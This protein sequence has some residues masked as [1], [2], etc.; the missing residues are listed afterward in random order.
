MGDIADA[1]LIKLDREGFFPAEGESDLDFVRRVDEVK[2]S[3][4]RIY[5]DLKRTG[6][7]EHL[8]C[9]LSFLDLIG[10][11][12]IREADAVTDENFSFCHPAGIGFFHSGKVGWLWGG[13]TFFSA[14]EP[15][16]LFFLRRDFAKKNKWHLY[17][18]DEILAHELC[19]VVRQSIDDPGMEE[20]FAYRTSFSAFRRACGDLFNSWIESLI[21]LLFVLAL[22]AAQFIKAF[23]LPEFPVQIFWS[24]FAIFIAVISFRTY[25]RHRLVASAIEKLQSFGVAKPLAVLFR[26]RSV[27]IARVAKLRDEKAWQN[28]VSEKSR[29]SLRW[30]IIALRFVSGNAEC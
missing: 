3:V 6:H 5:S 22:P 30:K 8:D 12:I 10:E 18:R 2:K 21:F 14:D 27:E 20:Y 13:C 17:R 4:A 9:K 26:L 25:R 19:H 11:T 28:L 29:Q 23:I 1:E 16:A 15:P 24:G 7:A